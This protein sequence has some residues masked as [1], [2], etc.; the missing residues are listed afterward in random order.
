[1]SHI[2]VML[3]NWIG[4][5]VMATPVLRA[6]RQHF[7]DRAKITGVMRPYVAEVLH[8]TTWLDDA[9][10][11][12]RHASQWNQRLVSVAQRLRQLRV[13]TMIHLTNSL[14]G[15]LLGRLAGVRKNVGYARYGRRFL[16][17]D[18]LEPPRQGKKLQPISAVDYYL[19][20]IRSIGIPGENRRVELATTTQEEQTADAVWRALG[21][22]PDRRVIVFNTGGAYGAAKHWPGEYFAQLAPRLAE[23][24]RATVLLICGPS[25]RT[26]AAEIVRQAAHPC[27]K[28]FAEMPLSIGL[29]KAAV[30]RSDLMVTTDS[31]PRHFASAF[32]VPSVALFGSTDP[33][34]SE[35]G[36]DDEQMLRQPMDCSPCAKRTCPLKHHRCMRSLTVDDVYAAVM[37]RWQ[38]IDKVR[39]A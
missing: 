30:R 22:A 10:F 38:R 36:H 23:A 37:Q 24:T 13:D 35:N 26:A 5:V 6:L 1:M 28:S 18:W 2:G 12:D 15:A 33:R 9:V 25:E 7:G 32:G 27:V 16:L 19:E 14:A 3:P 31:G 34:W 39:A 4:D 11:Y 29:S 20:L 8:G 21:I 17:T